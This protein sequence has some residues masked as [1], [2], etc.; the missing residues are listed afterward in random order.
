[1]TDTAAV[2]TRVESGYW[3]IT[4]SSRTRGYRIRRTINRKFDV[5]GLNINL[6]GWIWTYPT[7]KEA[8]EWCIK[9][10]EGGPA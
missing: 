4:N 10:I 6:G 5:E 3:E 9:K 7:F 1:M 8:R 2:I